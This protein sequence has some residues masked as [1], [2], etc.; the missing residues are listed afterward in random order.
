MT[1]A[2]IM[3]II[4]T[5]LIIL[6]II[7]I[8]IIIII[9]NN[10]F[11]DSKNSH[12]AFGFHQFLLVLLA[13]LLSLLLRSEITSLLRQEAGQ[14]PV[15]ADRIRPLPSKGT[16]SNLFSNAPLSTPKD[17]VCFIEM[18]YVLRGY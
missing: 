9:R 16:F 8:I 3:P 7:I 5:M 11:L 18:L 6:P 14:Y 4:T 1:V 13:H 2:I 17:N 15:L 10:E 12:H